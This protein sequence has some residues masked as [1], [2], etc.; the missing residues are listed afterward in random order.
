M[1]PGA[2]QLSAVQRFYAGD[3][4]KLVGSVLSAVERH[5]A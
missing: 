2:A 1:F 4:V 5:Y 3:Q